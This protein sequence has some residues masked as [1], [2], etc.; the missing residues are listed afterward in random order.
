ME[1]GLV[2]LGNAERWDSN[3]GLLMS[4]GEERTAHAPIILSVLFGLTEEHLSLN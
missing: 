3:P 1:Q 2:S 4:S